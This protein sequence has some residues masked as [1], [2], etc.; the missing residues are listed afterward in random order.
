[1]K[2]S[3]RYWLRGRLKRVSCNERIGFSTPLLNERIRVSE[4]GSD[5]SNVLL[6]VAVLSLGSLALNQG[7]AQA[8]TISYNANLFTDATKSTS[9]TANFL[10]FDSALGTLTGVTISSNLTGT[11]TLKVVNKDL[12][13]AQDFTDGIAKFNMTLSSSLGGSS[14]TK[15]ASSGTVD[16]TVAADTTSLFSG[17]AVNTSVSLSNLNLAD[18]IGNGTSTFVATGRVSAGNYSGTSDSSDISFGG[19]SI[20]SANATVTYT[21]TA[22]PSA[23]VPEPLTILGAATAVGF[24]VAFKRRALKN[25]KK[26]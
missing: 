22:T 4:I 6:G 18:Y 13:F 25:N 8:A 2:K 11:A 19:S 23:A 20:L 10:K 5:F 9:G 15:Q 12:L 7:N 24:G 17:N 14:S 21:Y 16:G 1:M 26:A 3:I